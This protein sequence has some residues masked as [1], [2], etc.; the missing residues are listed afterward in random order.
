MIGHGMAGGSCQFG[1][2]VQCAGGIK[3]Q[4]QKF[5]L[6]SLVVLKLCDSEVASR[7][8]GFG[9]EKEGYTIN[10]PQVAGSGGLFQNACN[11][12]KRGKWA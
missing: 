8:F 7:F 6:P 5:S 1:G 4:Q 9:V 10:L 12:Q 3:S 2:P 11:Q